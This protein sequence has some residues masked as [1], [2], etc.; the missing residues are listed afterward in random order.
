MVL[1]WHRPKTTVLTAVPLVA[2]LALSGCGGDASGTADAGSV[3]ESAP[4]YDQLPAEIQEAGT[5]EIGSSIDYPPF[6]YYAEDGKTL[7]GFEPELAEL[8]EK[9]LGVTFTWNNA[10]FD[11]LLPALSSDRYDIIYG[12]VNDT[13]EREQDYDFVYYLQSSQGFVT[14]AGNPEGIESVEDLCGKPI[15]AVRGGIQAEFLEKQSATCEDSGM[16]PID[17]LTFDGNA[18]EQLAVRQGKAAALL[19]NYPTA[20]VFAAES[21]GVLEVV[22]GLQVEQQFFG[23]VLQKDDTELR[24]ALVGAWQAIIDDGS[25]GEVL[26]K[27]GLEDIAVDE[28]GINAVETNAQP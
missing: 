16:E 18:Q 15:A 10:G 5:I 26:Q 22:E 8:L 11:T 12:A 13:A 20:A 7:E 17:V 1:R 21:D 9:K 4:F 19:E 14:L 27:W 24:D 2:A 6:E 3:D 28:A 23:M 25:Y